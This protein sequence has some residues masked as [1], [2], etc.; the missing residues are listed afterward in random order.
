[1][2]ASNNSIKMI[3]KYIII[4]VIITATCHGYSYN[5]NAGNCIPNPG[6]LD[7]EVDYDKSFQFAQVITESVS[8][9]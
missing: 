3:A 8:N 9:S 1:M 2:C 4:F 6:F 7:L 5:I